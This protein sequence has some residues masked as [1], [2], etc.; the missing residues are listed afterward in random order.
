MKY[1]VKQLF[2]YP[3][4]SFGGQQV[5]QMEISETGPKYDRKW[6]VVDEKGQFLT[7][8][9]YPKMSQVTARIIDDAHVELT[10]PGVD[11]MDF[12]TDEYDASNSLEVTVWKTQVK[13][14][15]VDPE[16]SQWVSDFLGVKC[17]LVRMDDEFERPID[18][19][20]G[21]GRI[22]FSDGFPFLI[23]SVQ[24]L[25]LLNQKLNKAFAVKRFRPNIVVQ[26]DEPH[27]EDYWTQ[28]QIGD[29]LFRGAKLCSR[30]K[31]TTIDP[32]TGEFGDEPL[33][34]LSQYRRTDQ[35]I[36]F[37]KNFVHENLG[38]IRQGMD[39]D[40]LEYLDYQPVLEEEEIEEEVEVEE[41][42]AE[43]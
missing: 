23:L 41:E 42:Y 31:I 27:Q 15:E 24:S 30:C 28:I 38:A 20:Y 36:V 16:V 39:V 12:G 13:A 34:T 8:R 9:Q 26:I 11:F 17:K 40:V 18:A 32:M 5:S 2:I 37:G 21:D 10:A 14:Y 3:V 1:K 29:V 19:D 4:K 35:G 25:E 6:M 22:N 7:Q 43:L 33:E